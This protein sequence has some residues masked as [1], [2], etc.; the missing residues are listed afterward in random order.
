LIEECGAQWGGLTVLVD[1]AEA[2]ARRRLEPF[3]AVVEF[4]ALPPSAG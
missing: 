2:D 1:Q 3:A 4:G